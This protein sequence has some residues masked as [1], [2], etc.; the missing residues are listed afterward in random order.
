M[1]FMEQIILMEKMSPYADEIIKN[2]N[3]GISEFV[4]SD[5]EIFDENSQTIIEIV[6]GAGIEAT[7]ENGKVFIIFD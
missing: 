7:Y 4:P 5:K 3:D 2:Y 6:S 1:N